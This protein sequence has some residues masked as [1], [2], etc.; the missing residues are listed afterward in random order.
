MAKESLSHLADRSIQ[1]LIDLLGSWVF[2][3]QGKQGLGAE[4]ERNPVLLAFN[5]KTPIIMPS[6]RNH[7]PLE[8]TVRDNCFPHTVSGSWE[9]HSAEFSTTLPF[10][11]LML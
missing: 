7:D 3:L 6:I 9:K 10:V 5:E 2:F 1:C 11:F 4:M 8:D